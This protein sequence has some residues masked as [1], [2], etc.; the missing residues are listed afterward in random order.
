MTRCGSLTIYAQLTQSDRLTEMFLSLSPS[1]LWVPC[2]A[3]YQV[4]KDGWMVGWMGLFLNML[5]ALAH[6]PK[7]LSTPKAKTAVY[8]NGAICII[9]FAGG[10]L[11][12][13]AVL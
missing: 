8:N 11:S 12:R 9:Y 10:A 7:S 5:S 4:T 6:A 3:R 2:R 13:C 1:A